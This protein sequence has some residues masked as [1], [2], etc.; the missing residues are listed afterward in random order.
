MVRNAFFQDR[1]F[2]H[3]PVLANPHKYHISR[4]RERAT[5]FEL[6]DVFSVFKSVHLPRPPNFDPTYIYVVL[7][8][9]PHFFEHL[10]DF[11]LL[12]LLIGVKERL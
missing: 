1:S 9:P 11:R 6:A 2:V 3:I 5:E 4:T 7:G 8:P 10:L 12:P